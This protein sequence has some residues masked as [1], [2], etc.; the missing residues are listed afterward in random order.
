[1]YTLDVLQ[2]D[3]KNLQNKNKCRKHNEQ[4]VSQL[5]MTDPNSPPRPLPEAPAILRSAVRRYS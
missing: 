1:M 3:N 2:Y 4:N 5:V